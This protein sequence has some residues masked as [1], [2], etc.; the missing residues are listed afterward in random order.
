M[1]K[2]PLKIM[3]IYELKERQMMLD[4]KFKKKMKIKKLWTR[5]RNY[6]YG[7]YLRASKVRKVN[8]ETNEI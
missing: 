7:F 5:G 4:N 3:E 6:F 1:K 2:E 8:K